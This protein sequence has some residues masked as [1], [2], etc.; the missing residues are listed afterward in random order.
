M[1]LPTC[2]EPMSPLVCPEVHA[3]KAGKDVFASGGNATDAAIAAAFVQG[4][5]NHLL[6]EIGG[7][8]PLSLRGRVG[9]QHDRQRRGDL[10]AWTPHGR[11]DGGA[12]RGQGSGQPQVCVANGAHE[13]RYQAIGGRPG[14]KH[15]Q[16]ESLDWLRWVLGLDQ[17]T[18]LSLQRRYRVYDPRPGRPNSIVAG[19]KFQGGSPLAVSNWKPY[20]VVGAPGWNPNRKVDRAVGSQCRRLRHGHANCCHPLRFHSQGGSTIYLEPAFDE[21][22]A[23]Q[24][25]AGYEIRRSR[26]QTRPQTIRIAGNR[27][28]GESDPRG[29]ARPDISELPAYD[30]ASDPAME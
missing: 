21:A 24:F 6:R 9:T 29:Q 14:G 16:P 8:Q 18:R 27:A 4:V 11:V 15:S 22:L 10:R 17:R 13:V 30:W 2:F 5:T 19:K 25:G 23:A 20:V 26:Y 12:R 28:E 7:D 1:Q 3:A